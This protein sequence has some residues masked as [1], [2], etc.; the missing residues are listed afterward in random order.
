MPVCRLSSGRTGGKTAVGVLASAEEAGA[1]SG[2]LAEL[3]GEV[4]AIDVTEE[5][6]DAVAEAAPEETEAPAGA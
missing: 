4:E 2:K 5:A 6:L 3:G 1:I